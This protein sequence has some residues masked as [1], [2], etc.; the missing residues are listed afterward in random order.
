MTKKKNQIDRRNDNAVSPNNFKNGTEEKDK[1]I[2]EYI[3]EK[4]KGQGRTETSIALIHDF[5][6][7]H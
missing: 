1:Y 2:E 5:E 4:E 3:E 7:S 6:L